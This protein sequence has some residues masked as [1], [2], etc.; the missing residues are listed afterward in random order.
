MILRFLLSAN[1]ISSSAWA[2][3]EVRGFSRKTC[4]PFCRAA[5][6]RSKCVQTGVTT[7]ILEVIGGAGSHQ[8]GSTIQVIIDEVTEGNWAAGGK[9]IS[10]V[11]IADTVGLAKSGER[12]AWVKAYFA[13]K[14]RQFASAGYP[15]DVGGL[16]TQG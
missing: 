5:L 1:S 11:S 3:F 10:I 7:A 4:L 9:T 14:A 13:A 16:I 8:P 12:F 2:A 15:S 6:A